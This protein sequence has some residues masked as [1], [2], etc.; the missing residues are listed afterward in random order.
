MAEEIAFLTHSSTSNERPARARSEALAGEGDSIRRV[1]DWMHGL[2]GLQVP[3]LVTGERGTGRRA[4]ARFLHAAGPHPNAP[5]VE[6]ESHR[7]PW[8]EA[9]PLRGSVFVADFE[10]QS[11]E[12]QAQWKRRLSA[13]PCGARLLFG[14]GP[15]LAERV[16][17]DGFDA[18]LATELARFELRLP[19]PPGESR[20]SP[21][22][23]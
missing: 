19:A 22:N 5:L 9:I 8:P 12:H 17:T 21:S 13:A 10:E 15:T 16:R 7:D 1:R 18:E 6:V 3:V 2:S 11:R 23:L 20:G 4:A 14:A